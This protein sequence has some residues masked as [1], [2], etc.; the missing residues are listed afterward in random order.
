M[1]KSQKK[2]RTESR[3]TFHLFTEEQFSAFPE[4]KITG[5]SSTVSEFKYIEIVPPRSL[6]F[7][8]L[9]LIESGDLYESQEFLLEHQLIST[10]LKIRNL[11]GI[12]KNVGNE[13]WPDTLVY[14][15]YGKE[16]SFLETASQEDGNYFPAGLENNLD[17]E[18][19]KSLYNLPFGKD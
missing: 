19:I 14:V 13:E 7:Q 11:L 6:R 9:K 2:N 15:N 10:P 8:L 17:Q 16:G 18:D 5:P 4:L 12:Y 3:E 1:G